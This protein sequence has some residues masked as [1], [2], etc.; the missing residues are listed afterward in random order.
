MRAGHALPA[1]LARLAV[2]VDHDDP[3]RLARG[4]ADVQ[5]LAPLELGDDPVRVGLAQLA[6]ADVE[7]DALCLVRPPQTAKPGWAKRFRD[8]MVARKAAQ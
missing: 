3:G 8:R 6:L 1:R 7:V 4:D 2:E 5:V